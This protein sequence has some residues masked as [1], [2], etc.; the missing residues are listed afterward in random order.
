MSNSEILS[1]VLLVLRNKKVGKK[2]TKQFDQ[3]IRDY[4]DLKKTFYF[5]FPESNNKD[6]N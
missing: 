1:K 3:F 5:T 4:N 2:I 6:E